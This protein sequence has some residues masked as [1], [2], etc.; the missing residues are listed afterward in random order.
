MPFLIWKFAE[1]KKSI[2]LYEC[3]FIHLMY[4]QGKMYKNDNI[5]SFEFVTQAVEAVFYR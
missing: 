5:A 4:D 1:M 2:K 3:P